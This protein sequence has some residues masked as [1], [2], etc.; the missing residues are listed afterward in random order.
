MRTDIARYRQ[1]RKTIDAAVRCARQGKI[2]DARAEALRAFQGRQ[3]ELGFLEARFLSRRDNKPIRYALFL[4]EQARFCE[5]LDAPQPVK[6]AL[7]SY[8]RKYARIGDFEET[9][10]THLL[11]VLRENMPNSLRVLFQLKEYSERIRE[12]FAEIDQQHKRD[13]KY[14]DAGHAY[15][16]CW[17][18]TQLLSLL[19]SEYGGEKLGITATLLVI[20]D[21]AIDWVSLLHKRGFTRYAP[22]NSQAEEDSLYTISGIRARLGLPEPMTSNF[23]EL[24]EERKEELNRNFQWMLDHAHERNGVFCSGKRATEILVHRGV[25]PDVILTDIELG[26]GRANGLQIA[27]KMR[28]EANREGANPVIAVYSSNIEKYRAELDQLVHEGVIDFYFDKSAWSEVDGI[29]RSFRE[30]LT[31]RRN[32]GRKE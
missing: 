19:I 25:W 2:E 26:E 12:W 15:Q 24:Y 28:E 8:F 4:E 31:R 9:T 17:T 16:F 18:A 21:G 1:F 30:A 11:K 10:Y 29:I 6:D 13:E 32:S 14:S 22:C 3:L 20:E 5:Q 23:E 7:I 27:R